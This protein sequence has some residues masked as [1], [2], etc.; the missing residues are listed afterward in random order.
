MLVSMIMPQAGHMISLD[1]QQQCMLP[2]QDFLHL[3]CWGAGAIKGKTNRS[4]DEEIIGMRSNPTQQKDHLE[5]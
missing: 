5:V 3:V 2:V 1:S 4:L